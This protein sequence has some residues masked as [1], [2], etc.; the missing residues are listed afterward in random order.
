[1]ITILNFVTFS[2]TCK[3]ASLRTYTTGVRWVDYDGRII[4]PF[5]D[6]GGHQY[7]CGTANLPNSLHGQRHDSQG[8]AA[9]RRHP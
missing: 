7:D 8:T 5:A 6:S 1:M 9:N 3:L 4:G 2:E